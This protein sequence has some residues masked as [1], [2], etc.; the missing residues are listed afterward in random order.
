MAMRQA[1]DVLQ[2]SRTHNVVV[3]HEKTEFSRGLFHEI[4][5]VGV[6]AQVFVVFKITQFTGVA[7]LVVMHDPG[8]LLTLGRLIFADHD[9]KILKVLW[10]N[11]IQQ[12]WKMACA[13]VGG[14]ADRKKPASWAHAFSQ[15]KVLGLKTL[16]DLAGAPATIVFGGTQPRTTELAPITAPL[17]IVTGPTITE[18]S[19]IQTFSPMVTGPAPPKTR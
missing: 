19:P 10:Q 7:E 6:V 16:M 11:R 1:S 18:L 12:M 3:A 9:L 15:R 17:P 13:V 2:S 4:A 14:N 5:N 8:N